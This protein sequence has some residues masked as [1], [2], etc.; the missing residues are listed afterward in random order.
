MVQG[1]FPLVVASAQACATVAPNGIDFIDE[2]DTGCV[3]FALDEQI[4][5][6]GSANTDKHL[7]KIGT[8]DGIERNLGFAG[9]GL[10]Q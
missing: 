2:N 4:T 5:H 6:P 3:F 10:G 9:N 8:A 1:L 7:D